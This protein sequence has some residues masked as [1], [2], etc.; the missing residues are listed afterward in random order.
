[1]SVLC[2]A[3]AS[4]R[5]E[6]ES[7]GPA[8]IYAMRTVLTFLSLFLFLVLSIPLFLLFKLI[9]VFNRRACASL[10]QSV[11]NFGFRMVLLSAGVKI[12]C[13]GKENVPTDRAVLYTANHRSYADIPIGYLTVP[14]VTGFIAKKQIKKVPSLSWWMTN[15]NC[16]FLDRDDMRQ[17][18]KTI[19]AAIDN[20][21]AGFSMF[22]MPEGTRNHQ[23]EMLPFKEGTFKIAIKSGCPIIPVAITNSDAIYELHRPWVRKANVIIHYGKPIFVED[24]TPEETKTIGA[25]VRG[26][27]AGMLEE[28]APLLK[29][30]K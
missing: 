26:I 10:S 24:L 18:M 7:E 23:D 2:R 29:S 4:A 9:G 5:A 30:R 16:L 1:M 8:R 21:K 20:I 11:V 17:G 6:A 19:L 15:M 27:I 14:G 13:I 28:D 12:R 25:H 3:M 22:V